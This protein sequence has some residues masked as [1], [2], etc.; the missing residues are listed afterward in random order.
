ML[1]SSLNGVTYTSAVV[2][3][4]VVI[5]P[6]I[7]IVPAA[8]SRSIH[9]RLE[10]LEYLLDNAYNGAVHLPDFANAT[11]VRQQ[12]A[13]LIAA[14]QATGQLDDDILAELVQVAALL[15]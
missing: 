10:R 7:P 12:L 4:A 2:S 14:I 9:S 8:A 6:E 5:T 3:G 11:G 1:D 15:A 13:D